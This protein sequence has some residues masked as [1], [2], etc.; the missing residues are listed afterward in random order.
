VASGLG[1]ISVEQTM[2]WLLPM[3]GVLLIV[4]MI[5][6]Y[7]PGLSMFLPNLLRSR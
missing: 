5:F 3:I 4:L 1:G 2:K 6:T 7:S